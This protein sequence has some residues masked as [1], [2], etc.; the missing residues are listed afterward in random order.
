MAPHSFT[1]ARALMT[2]CAQSRKTSVFFDFYDVNMGKKSKTDSK[3]SGISFGECFLNLGVVV[4]TYISYKISYFCEHLSEL[5]YNL[6]Y[7]EK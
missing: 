3:F 6:I 1:I 7:S 5:I 4:T 2:R